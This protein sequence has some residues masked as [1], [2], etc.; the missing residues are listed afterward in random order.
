MTTLKIIVIYF[1]KIN[2]LIQFN[3]LIKDYNPILA[4]MVI[5]KMINYFNINLFLNIDNLLNK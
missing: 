2:E 5:T 4:I 3:L 1:I